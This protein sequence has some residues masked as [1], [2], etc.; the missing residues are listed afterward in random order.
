VPENTLPEVNDYL[1]E[2]GIATNLT[3]RAIDR[4]LSFAEKNVLERWARHKN[5]T[6]E[7]FA[8]Y[9][10]QKSRRCRQ[11]RNLFNDS[12]SSNIDDVYVPTRF[13]HGLIKLSENDLFRAITNTNISKQNRR[14]HAAIIRGPAGSGKSLF[15][16]HAFL[17]LQKIGQNRIPIM[18]ELRSL[19]SRRLSNPNNPEV[20][21]WLHILQSEISAYG[22]DISV[23]QVEDAL[24]YGMF[25]IIL[26]GIDE[27]KPKIQPIYERLILELAK[28]YPD[29]PLLL[30]GRPMVRMSSWTDFEIYQ[31][32]PLETREAISIVQKSN[33]NSDTKARFI[34]LV[35]G[36]LDS[37][38]LKFLETPLLVIIMLITFSDS[39]KVSRVRHEFYEDA[40]NALWSKH[41]A[42]K[43]G[44]ERHKYS[45][46]QKRDF[47]QL[48]S[49]FSFASYIKS[50]FEMRE[51]IFSKHF[52]EATNASQVK[53]LEEDF[54]QDMLVSTSLLIEDGL[55]LKFC[56]RSFQEYFTSLC[57]SN[58]PNSDVP[59]AISL[60]LDRYETDQVLHFL[61]SHSPEVVERYWILPELE[62]SLKA[63]KVQENSSLSTFAHSAFSLNSKNKFIPQKTNLAA[64]RQLYEF[65]PTTSELEACYTAFIDLSADSLQK[66]PTMSQQ[67][68]K[69]FDKDRSSLLSLFGELQ[70]K[71][72]YSKKASKLLLGRR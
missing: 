42:R 61:L 43:E 64:I 31:I 70:K 49:W 50:D 68:E 24:K 52:L 1:D 7:S 33:I 65:S 45:G 34:N 6:F 66:P 38:Y 14:A 71:Y 35:I 69:L 58:M 67:M 22:N 30:A 26:D 27:I 72:N 39:G 16:K 63:L 62:S 21:E 5:S 54:R 29:C 9:L 37:G 55:F 51:S 59:S 25:V 3:K 2:K 53:V 60:V 48:L 11:V 10:D 40:F 13:M 20:S 32:A 46:L 4:I 41:D 19:N 18:L 8:N 36:N 44:F 12:T 23:S 15:L 57:I 56:H 17:E 47:V 28:K